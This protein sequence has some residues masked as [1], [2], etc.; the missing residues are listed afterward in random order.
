[1][2]VALSVPLSHV[3]FE[4]DP[5]WHLGSLG[6]RITTRGRTRVSPRQASGP[7][8]FGPL[9]GPVKLHGGWGRGGLTWCERAGKTDRPTYELTMAFYGQTDLKLAAGSHLSHTHEKH[10]QDSR[11]AQVPAGSLGEPLPVARQQEHAPFPI[12]ARRRPALPRASE[13][14]PRAAHTATPGGGIHSKTA[15]GRPWPP[16]LVHFL[17]VPGP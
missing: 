11:N 1:M 5:E 14:R 12:P 2:G 8:G 6:L 16:F 17:P 3:V 9:T 4:L 15:P 13:T 7:P 10:L